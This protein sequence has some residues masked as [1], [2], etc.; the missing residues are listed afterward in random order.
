MDKPQ[1]SPLNFTPLTTEAE[2]KELLGRREEILRARPD[3]KLKSPF[4][5]MAGQ[6]YANGDNKLSIMFLGIDTTEKKLEVDGYLP[7]GETA[8]TL[9]KSF[10]YHLTNQGRSRFWGN[11]RKTVIAITN[12][13]KIC[14]A[15]FWPRCAWANGYKISLHGKKGVPDW[16]KDEQR[17][18]CA[19]ILRKKIAEHKPTVIVAFAANV[20]CQLANELVR[21]DNLCYEDKPKNLRFY[22]AH[23]TFPAVAQYRNDRYV[24]EADWPK[25]VEFIYQQK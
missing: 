15:E 8:K 4:L 7:Y 3:V 10:E 17:D 16:L 19:K 22:R 1:E 23:E 5:D 18:L 12:Q 2:F 14:E 24:E 13:L 20:L 9:G 6:S 21:T 25:I 11:V